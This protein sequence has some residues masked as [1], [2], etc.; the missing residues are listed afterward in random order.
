MSEIVSLIVRPA[1]QEYLATAFTEEDHTCVLS[2]LDEEGLSTC[3]VEIKVR[4]KEVEAKRTAITGPL[5]AAKRAVDELFRPTLQRLKSAEQIVKERLAQIAYAREETN[6]ALLLAASNSAKAGE[7]QQATAA[8]QA[9]EV[10]EKHEGIQI[11]ET[12]DFEVMDGSLVPKTFLAIDASK[13]K[14]AIASGVRDI[15]G[16]K[17]YKRKSIAIR[18]SDKR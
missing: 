4:L 16:L 10:Q 12:W 5:N 18:T 11:R 17:I 15:P 2:E 6:R 9:I 7:V 3:A 1:D 8:I 14:A 13:V